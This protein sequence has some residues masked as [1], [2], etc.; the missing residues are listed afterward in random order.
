M[1]PRALIASRRS[2]SY[3]V[4]SKELRQQKCLAKPNITVEQTHS[5]RP[6]SDLCFRKWKPCYDVPH[7]GNLSLIH[8]QKF[9]MPSACPTNYFISARSLQL[10]KLT[11]RLDRRPSDS[12]PPGSSAHRLPAQPQET[13]WLH[14]EPPT[15]K[16]KKVRSPLEAWH[17]CVI[18]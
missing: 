9:S 2:P 8:L 3:F 6:T 1:G 16:K 14:I 7:M 10:V 11:N 17:D 13:L 4:S 5:V 12:C 15:D 18:M